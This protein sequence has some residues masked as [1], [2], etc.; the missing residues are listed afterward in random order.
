VLDQVQHSCT[1]EHA[2]LPI[3]LGIFLFC[4]L[5]LSSCIPKAVCSVSLRNGSDQE[6]LS[7]RIS[8]AAARMPVA[9]D[10]PQ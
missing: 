3:L 4:A 8:A 1:E 6:P 2:F 7:S 5:S 9:I 10:K